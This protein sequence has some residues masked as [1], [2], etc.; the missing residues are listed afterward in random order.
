MAPEAELLARLVS[1][2]SEDLAVDLASGPGTLALRFAK[3]VRWM[4]AYDLTPAIL[5]RARQ[6]A[7]Q[8]GLL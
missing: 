6:K 3:H 4:C 1:A 2:G 8:E 7:A 5:M